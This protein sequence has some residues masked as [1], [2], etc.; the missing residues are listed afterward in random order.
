MAQGSGCTGADAAAAANGVPEEQQD[1]ART[2][3]HGDGT[4]NNDDLFPV[5]RW[6]SPVDYVPLAT[7]KAMVDVMMKRNGK[8]E[9]GML[10]NKPPH[11]VRKFRQALRQIHESTSSAAAATTATTPCMT[12]SQACSLRRHHIKL[13][14]PFQ[15]M[16]QLGLGE[17]ADILES[18]RI[19]E[20]AVES[21]LKDAGMEYLTE[22]AQRERAQ[23]D[24]EPLRATPDFIFP[25]P[26]LL[27]KVR[28]GDSGN[29]GDSNEVVLEERV[30]HWIEAKMYYGASTIPAGKRN[31][32]VG[33]VRSTAQKYVDAFGEGAMLFMMGCGDGLAS[34]LGEIGVSVLD[35]ADAATVSLEEVHKH[36][37]TWCA[38]G[39]GAI[40]P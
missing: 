4:I 2:V 14:N 10:K 40:L 6:P 35:A 36:Q 37:R 28:C 25:R 20:A 24:Q 32:A 1:A 33:T 23:N 16:T 13:L 38:N 34:D 9:R 39:D 22:K 3:G 29:T 7:E 18:A 21:C 11:V 15:R 27:R 8:N 12:F 19:F 17:E 30:V 26:V 5:L 31:G